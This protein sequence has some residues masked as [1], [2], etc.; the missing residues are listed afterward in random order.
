MRA[1]GRLW[2]LALAANMLAANTLIATEP[3]AD[4]ARRCEAFAGQEFPAIPDA[5][6]RIDS[7]VSVA[8]SGDLPA[9][10]ALQATIKPNVGIELRLPTDRWNRKFFQYGRGGYC[11]AISM[12]YCDE[13]LRKGYACVITD[14]GHKSN[15]IDDTW[16]YD[17]LQARVDCGFRATHVATV[18]GKALTE[19]FYAKPPAHAYYMG[20]S[21]GGRLG[22]IEAQRFPWDFDGIVVGAPPANKSATGL[23]LLWAVAATLD[24]AGTPL[25][26]AADIERVAQAALARCDRD[27][28]VADGVI[29][30]PR[31]CHFDPGELQCREPAVSGG[32]AARCLRADQVAALRKIYQGPVTS[33]GLRLN[34]GAP[35]PGSELN[36]VGSFVAR[37]GNVSAVHESMTAMFRYMNDPK[38]GPDWDIRQFN[39]DQDYKRIALA[40]AVNNAANPDLRA[41]KAA[42]GKLMIFHGL[43][44]E[45][46]TTESVIDYF[47]TVSRTMGGARTTD[48]FLRLYLLA[49]FNHCSGG[50]GATVVD[51]ISQLENWV[52][53]GVAPNRLIAA[54]LKSSP[55]GGPAAIRFPLDPANI[56]FTRLVLPYRTRPKP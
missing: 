41:F 52:E 36:W 49:G 17:N 8:A 5:P 3:T 42:G 20:C 24:A 18:A 27:D 25:L 51:Y 46:I 32:G 35:L 7:A 28:G 31:G 16:M 44:D 9:Y 22:L 54:K 47:E 29:G 48:E 14:H 26:S 43:A 23:G 6:T 33:G 11:R 40:E 56:A 15:E 37:D 2:P 4:F 12:E 13:P 34:R 55:A 38:L 19:K 53:R 39:W 50:V 10:C 45:L 30:N 1:F 21:T